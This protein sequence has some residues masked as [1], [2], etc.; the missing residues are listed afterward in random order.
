MQSVQL[1]AISRDTAGTRKSR[2]LRR[3]GYIPA[4]MYGRSGTNTSLSI[5]TAEFQKL[6]R[7]VLGSTALIEL[8]VDNGASHTSLIQEVQRNARNDEFL[9]ID[10]HEVSAK[11]SIHTPVAVHIK[12][13][14]IGVKQENGTLE[15]VLHEVEVRC[16]PKDLP[17]YVE[18]DISELHAGDAVH[19]RQLP[20]FE[21]VEYLG[22]PDQVV[23]SCQVAKGGATAEDDEA[24]AEAEAAAAEEAEAS[25]SEESEEKAES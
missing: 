14:S 6:W 10:F 15:V 18:I 25:E 19:I 8:K 1:N 7:Q 5:P 23:V 2:Q 24:E 16:L 20:T 12:G 17:S 22:D 3:A 13:E 9:H 11:E 21:G 4:V